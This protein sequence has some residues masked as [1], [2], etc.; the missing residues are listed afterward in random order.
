[1][2]YR[3]LHVSFFQFLQFYVVVPGNLDFGD[4][5]LYFYSAVKVLAE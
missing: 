4:R 1:M 5:P 2:P 3:I